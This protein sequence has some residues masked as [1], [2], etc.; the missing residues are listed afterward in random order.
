[1]V[2]QSPAG[3]AIERWAAKAQNGHVFVY[4]DTGAGWARSPRAFAAARALWEAKQVFLFQRKVGNA[5]QWCALKCTPQA[6]N[7]LDIVS[8][9][10]KVAPSREYLAQAQYA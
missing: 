10:L 5:W 3:H 1:M 7:V 2:D 6:R 8:K 9:Q 4:H